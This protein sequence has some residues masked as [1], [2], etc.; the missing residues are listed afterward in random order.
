[1]VKKEDIWEAKSVL[2]QIDEI[3]FDESPT[4]D[5]SYRAARGILV[6]IKYQADHLKKEEKIALVSRLA[7]IIRLARNEAIK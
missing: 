6:E 5:W 2:K 3:P 4:Y 7:A 1:M